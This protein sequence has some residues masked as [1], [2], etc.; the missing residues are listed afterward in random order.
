M[1][2]DLPTVTEEKNPDKILNTKNPPRFST[3]AEPRR[4]V[5]KMKYEI[6]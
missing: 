5:K 1:M 3:N 2:E 4:H 6:I